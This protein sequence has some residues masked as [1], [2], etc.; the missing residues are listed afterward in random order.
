MKRCPFWWSL[1]FIKERNQKL[2]KQSLLPVH[3]APEP[4]E[5]EQLSRDLSSFWPS[6]NSAHTEPTANAPVKILPLTL[7]TLIKP[8]QSQQPRH[9]AVLNP[10]HSLVKKLS[11]E[12]YFNASYQVVMSHSVPQRYSHSVRQKLP[13]RESGRQGSLGETFCDRTSSQKAASRLYLKLGF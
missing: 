13:P 11:M 10:S 5:S 9:R 2:S 3:D 4:S 1:R 6:T 12:K 7:G 8:P